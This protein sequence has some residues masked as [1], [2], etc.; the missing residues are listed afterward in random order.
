MQ[1]FAAPLREQVAILLREEIVQGHLIPGERL[2]EKPLCER[3][4]VSRSVIRE[5]LRQLESESLVSMKP[6]HGA[7]VTKLS[8]KD[9]QSLYEVRQEL[10]G[11][12]TELFCLRANE[13]QSSQMKAL[14]QELKPSYLDGSLESRDEIKNR[15]Y[16]VLLEGADNPVLS[17]SLEQIHD[18]IGVFRHFS[19]IDQERVQIAYEELQ[20]I[21]H[22]LTVLEDPVIARQAAEH[23][24]ERAGELAI[25]EYEK[26]LLNDHSSS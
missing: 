19:F 1:R 13:T 4:D 7:E 12:A 2:Y 3:Y 25:L 15:F 23:H 10:E 5:V 9:I 8:P 16:E 14:A 22:A 17:S 26:R 18:R 20:T 21:I 24:I 6:G 11:L